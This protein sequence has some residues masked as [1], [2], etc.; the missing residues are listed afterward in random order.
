MKGERSTYLKRNYCRDRSPI[1]SEAANLNNILFSCEKFFQNLD[2][3]PVKMLYLAFT[4][5]PKLTV[6]CW[7]SAI[8]EGQTS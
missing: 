5:S 6:F 1:F 7:Y 8:L 3:A 2:L 4:S